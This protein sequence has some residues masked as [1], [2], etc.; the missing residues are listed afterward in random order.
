L[1]ALPNAAKDRDTQIQIAQVQEKAKRFA[2]QAKSLDAAEALSGSPQEKQVIEFMR[3]AM[4]ERQK[5]FDAAEQSFRK[6]LAADPTNAGALNYLGYMFAD[7]GVKLDEAHQMISKALELDPGNGAYLD[8]LGWALFR[9]NRLDEAAAELNKALV[10][11]GKDPTVH[12]H[13]AEVYSKQGK[14]KEAIQQWEASLTEMKA[15][16]PSEQ[17]A[18]ELAKITRK[19]DS[20]KLRAQGKK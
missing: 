16:P 6:V 17:D 4:Y 13:L 3:G 2:D 10:K 18:E 14:V 15:A 1:R 12:D 19:L 20:A 7:R 8:S 9:L 5:N 11:I